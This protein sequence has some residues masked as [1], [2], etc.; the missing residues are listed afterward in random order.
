MLRSYSRYLKYWEQRER[1]KHLQAHSNTSYANKSGQYYQLISNQRAAVASK[2]Y[3]DAIVGN[4]V[5]DYLELTI[6]SKGNYYDIKEGRV[7][8]NKDYGEVLFADLHPQIQ[9]SSKNNIV[10]TTVQGRDYTRKEYVSGGDLE[11]SVTG[12]IT[13]KYPEVYPEAEVSKFLRLMQFKG[14]LDCDNTIL[15]QFGITQPD[16][17]EL[18][19]AAAYLPQCAALYPAMRGCGAGR[20]DT[21]Q[22][23]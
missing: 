10:L 11:I 23:E 3:A 4:K 6:D 7:R 5:L 18:Q 21:G 19:P 14:V 16:R 17:T 8:E 1:D 12:K 20:N 2:T 13:S 9:V 22:T 15:R